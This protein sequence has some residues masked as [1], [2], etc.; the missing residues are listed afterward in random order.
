MMTSL[1]MR[2]GYDEEM[3]VLC[4]VC[5]SVPCFIFELENI[6]IDTSSFLDLKSNTACRECS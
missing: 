1:S 5:L 6:S 3:I 4:C 2:A